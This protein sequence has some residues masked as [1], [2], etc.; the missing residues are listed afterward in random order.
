MLLTHAHSVITTAS[1]PLR[2]Y[3]YQHEG[4]EDYVSN[5]PNTDSSED[6]FSDDEDDATAIM[7]GIVC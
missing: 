4:M 2:W 7:F 5:E 6:P 1:L 3:R